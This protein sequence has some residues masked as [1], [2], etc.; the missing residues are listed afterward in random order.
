M[1]KHALAAW[2]LLAAGWAWAQQPAAGIEAALR[3]AMR[4]H[5][6]V[7]GK[8]AQ[9][10][11]KAHAGDAVR[12]Q[13]YPTLSA[14]AQRYADTPQGGGSAT[15]VTLRARQPLWA[16]GR[17]DNQIAYSDADAQAERADLLRV[18][19]Q[20]LENTAL[21]YATVLSSRRRLQLAQENTQAHQALFEQIQRRERGQLASRADVNLAAT[22]LAQAVAREQRY[23][24]ELEVALSELL[25]WTQQPVAAEQP[26]PPQ[27]TALPG[28]E[29]VLEMALGRS[30]ELAHKEQL[31]ER[32]RAAVEQVRSA[33]MPTVYLQ[34]EHWRQQPG[35]A[36]DSRVSVVVE[37]AFEGLGGA[38]RGQTQAALSQLEAAQQ[39]LLSAR[40]D[41]GRNVR[42]LYGNRQMLQALIGTQAASLQDLATLL[43]S[44]KRQYE[45][46]TKSWL[47]LLNMQR[48]ASE[49]LLQQVQAEGDWLAQSLQLTALVGGFDRLAT[50]TRE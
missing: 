5:P 24:G 40:N 38:L 10:D 39:E 3:S 28:A 1:V 47:D 50:G 16:F 27:L 42:R 20:V 25:A 18:Q 11:A 23:G 44:Y 4:L 8:Q 19:R 13:R 26:V 34:A 6:V 29:A 30:A 22:R 41:A 12:S 46:G 2:L 7:G 36:R 21:T 14:Q 37:G 43:D 15:P 48:E 9:V 49:Q 35:M 33:A 32:A 17:I 45:A 31:V